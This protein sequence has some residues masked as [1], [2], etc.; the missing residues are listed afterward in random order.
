LL[1]VVAARG[2]EMMALAFRVRG[3]R[4]MLTV[5]RARAHVRGVP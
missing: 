2:G 5:K 3:N 4:G 1:L